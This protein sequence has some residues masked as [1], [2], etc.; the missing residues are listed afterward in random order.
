M[1]VCAH[2]LSDE[3]VTLTMPGEASAGVNC[4]LADRQSAQVAVQSPLYRSS[5][6]NN[7]AA[8]SLHTNS[9]AVTSTGSGELRLT[10]TS[11]GTIGQPLF[12]PFNVYV[13]ASSATV[14]AINSVS[15]AKASPPGKVHSQ[16]ASGSDAFGSNVKLFPSQISMGSGSS[17][18]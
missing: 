15:P 11:E 14:V 3:Y 7:T 4:P 17:G 13:P 6:D 12:V 16:V 1:V 8:A 18:A 9:G 10:S 5:V 2:G